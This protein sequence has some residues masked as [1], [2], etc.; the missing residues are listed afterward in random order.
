M[1]I[2]YP[3]S[4][5]AE[6]KTAKITIVANAVVGQS[7]SPYTL[8]EQ[9][10]VH[11]GQRIEFSMTMPPMPRDKAEA[12][13]GF[14]LQLNAGEGTC[15]LGDTANKLPRG[16]ATGVPL[17]NGVATARS[18]DLATDGWTAGVTNI[19]KVG[20]WIQVGTG[21]TRR[22]HKLTQSVDSNGSGQATLVLWPRLRSAY[23]D[24]TPIT[25]NNP[26][27]VFRLADVT[28][29]DIDT[30]KIYGISATFKESLF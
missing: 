14:L 6:F 27:G 12:V 30:A 9:V 13:I 7:E 15:Y 17:V 11:Q 18:T 10:Y 22:L 23:A 28:T 5:P 3:L 4:L 20:D 2:S 1:P 25:V 16:V 29:W 21:S 8:S 24:N 26:T 19:L